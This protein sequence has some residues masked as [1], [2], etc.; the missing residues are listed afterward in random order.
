MQASDVTP[1]NK[2]LLELDVP[3]RQGHEADL[4]LIEVVRREDE[5]GLHIQVRKQPRNVNSPILPAVFGA[6]LG[7][8]GRG[9]HA[10]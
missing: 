3:Q 2:R 7:G 10:W 6:R 4:S 8:K 9:A 1:L 5:I